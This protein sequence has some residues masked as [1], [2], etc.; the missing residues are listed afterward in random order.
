MKQRTH[1]PAAPPPRVP[2]K[3]VVPSPQAGSQ[4]VRSPPGAKL[5]K[6]P[7]SPESRAPNGETLPPPGVGPLLPKEGAPTQDPDK[8]GEPAQED[9]ADA[10]YVVDSDTHRQACAD[11]GIDSSE[12]RSSSCDTDTDADDGEPPRIKLELETGGGAQIDHSTMV[13]QIVAETELKPKVVKDVLRVLGFLIIAEL[14]VGN[15]VKI[16][17]LGTFTN[18]L[19]RPGGPDLSGVPSSPAE[20]ES[21]KTLKTLAITKPTLEIS[22]RLRK[23]SVHYRL[24]STPTR[25]L[26]GRQVA[27][28]TSFQRRMIKD[29]LQEINDIMKRCA[30]VPARHGKEGEDPGPAHFS[31]SS[32]S[33]S[34]S[35]LT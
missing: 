28:I 13:H 15:S 11:A 23:Y 24:H 17:R 2:A 3:A 25:W 34:R 6:T 1:A 32:S 4:P 19:L 5:I 31:T 35:V 16:H 9:G 29:R 20:R 22:P 26:Q 12:D 14:R 10:A 21:R 7:S 18:L 33:S 30:R 27:E 8:E